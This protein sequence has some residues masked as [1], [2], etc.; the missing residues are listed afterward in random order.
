[1][2]ARLRSNEGLLVKLLGL[3]F[4]VAATTQPA[5]IRGSGRL[6]EVFQPDFYRRDMQLYADYLRLEEWQRPIVGSCSMTTR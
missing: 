5:S 2:T 1:M 3:A 4:V 6:Q